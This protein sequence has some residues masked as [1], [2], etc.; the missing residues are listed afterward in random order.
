MCQMITNT[1]K[2]IRDYLPEVIH[3]S[4]ATSENNKPWICEVHFAFDEDLNFYFQSLPSRRHSKEIEENS[5]VS[6]SIVK[7]HFV[8]QDSRG[9]FFDGQAEMLKNVDEKHIAYK[10][11][12]E[13]FGIKKSFLEELKSENGRKLFKIIVNTFYIF[14]S[15]ES[16]PAHKYTLQWQ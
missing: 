15:V 3:M 1:E 16:S 5:Y 8:G 2:V 9:I 7:Q 11:Y 14:D 12:S 6:G 10:L 4:L 13:R